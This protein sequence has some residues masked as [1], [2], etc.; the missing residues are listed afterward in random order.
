MGE[1]VLRQDEGEQHMRFLCVFACM[2]Q[3][4]PL[5]FFSLSFSPCDGGSDQ[6]GEQGDT[7]DIL[8]ILSLSLKKK[9]KKKKCPLCIQFPP[10]SNPDN[11]WEAH[12]TLCPDGWSS[13]ESYASPRRLP[14]WEDSGSKGVRVTFSASSG[15]ISSSRAGRQVSR[16][17]I[18]LG[19]SFSG[20][21]TENCT[22]SRPFSKGSRYTGMPSPITHLIALSLITSPAKTKTGVSP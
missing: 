10:L 20:N 17:G 6:L 8:R 11:Q 15:M 12:C 5:H 18:W 3:H 22:I 9:K 2:D 7:D 19:S 16:A 21:L 4:F 13:S 14:D 1:V